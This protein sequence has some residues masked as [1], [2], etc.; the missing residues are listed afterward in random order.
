MNVNDEILKFFPLTPE[1]R[2][3]SHHFHQASLAFPGCVAGVGFLRAQWLED[4]WTA[5]KWLA[6]SRRKLKLP[7]L[8]QA[9][10]RTY[11]HFCCF[12]L[13]D[14]SHSPARFKRRVKWL[15]PFWGG[16]ACVHKNEEM[17]GS[18]LWRSSITSPIRLAKM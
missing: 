8:V 13:V 15:H 3:R 7:F 9:R 12:Q 16:A 14:T 5:N 17:G 1:T 2:Q 10:V 11:P 6:F 4:N 18:Y